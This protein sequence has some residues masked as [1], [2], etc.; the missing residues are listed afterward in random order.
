VVQTNGAVVDQTPGLPHYEVPVE[1]ALGS[2]VRRMGI[3]EGFDLSLSQEFT[4]DHSI[5]VPLHFLTPRMRT[6]LVPIFINGIAPPLPLARR[7]FALGQMVRTAVQ[8]WRT[9]QRV[10]ILASGSFSLEVTGPKVRAAN[11]IWDVPDRAW[12]HRIVGFLRAGAVDDLL[13]EATEEH[14]LAAGNVAGELLNWIALLGVIGDRRPVF[15]EPQATHG[16]AFA[17]WRWD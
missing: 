4:L 6:A 14:M 5:L 3:G 17:A 7:C 9:N 1:A 15:A 16:H 12:M 2:V 11:G 8:A 10:A 13:N